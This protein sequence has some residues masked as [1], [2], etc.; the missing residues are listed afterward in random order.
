MKS[1]LAVFVFAAWAFALSSA[2]A[3]PLEDIK[4]TSDRAPDCSSLEALV[5]SV[6]RD[7]KT[8]DERAIA[9]YNACYY[10]YYHHAYPSEPGEVGALK[11]LNVYGWSLCGGEHTVLAALWEKSGFK[12]RYRGWSNPGHTTVECFYGGRW[13]YLDTFLRFF[14]WMPD[15]AAPGGRTIA[16]QDDIKANPALVTDGF[17]TDPADRKSVV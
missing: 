16:G 13:H 8:D 14:A 3:A 11:M 5:A 4:I 10:L 9:I 17:V 6:T 1:R 15:P 2:G 12:W 7:C